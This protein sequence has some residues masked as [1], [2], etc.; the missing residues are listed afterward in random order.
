MEYTLDNAIERFLTFF[1][2]IENGAFSADKVKEVEEY[3]G[4][5][6]VIFEVPDG[7]L[8]DDFADKL[9][10]FFDANCLFRGTTT[11]DGSVHA[12]YYDNPSEKDLVAI[13]VDGDTEG[14]VTSVSASVYLDPEALHGELLGALEVSEKTMT[15]TD[16]ADRDELERQFIYIV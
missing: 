2:L 5:D 16:I 11:E 9:E 8:V 1:G 3:D 4:A 12:V 14:Q 7:L 13:W 15:I 6:K 10:T